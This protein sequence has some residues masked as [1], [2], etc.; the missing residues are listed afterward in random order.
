MLFIYRRYIIMLSLS[1][2]RE[3]KGTYL[4]HAAY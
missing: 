4:D 2:F 3:V 1:L